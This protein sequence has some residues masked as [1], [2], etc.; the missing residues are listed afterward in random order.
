[1][2]NLGHLVQRGNPWI[3]GQIINSKPTCSYIVSYSAVTGPNC[4]QPPNLNTL[5]C[6][7]MALFH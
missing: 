6:N 5:P 4:V 7:L 3:Y 1:M 2:Q